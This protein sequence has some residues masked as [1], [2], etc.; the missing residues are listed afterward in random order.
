MAGEANI[1]EPRTLLEL[2]ANTKRVE[3]F[4]TA[5]EGQTVFTIPTFAYVPDTGALAIFKN[6]LA[7]AKGIDWVESGTGTSFSLVI[8]ASAGDKI[9]AV[10]YVGIT[11]E[12]AV[13]PAG[14]NILVDNFQD[15]R[16][17]AEDDVTLYSTSK[18]AIGDGGEGFF[19]LFTGASPGTYADNNKTIIVPTGGNGSAAWIKSTISRVELAAADSDVSI[20][21]VA[22]S[23]IANRAANGITLQLST[24]AGTDN[25]VDEAWALLLVDVPDG[26]CRIV[27]DANPNTVSGAWEIELPVAIP[28]NCHLDL[29]HTLIEW[30]STATG[31]T[32]K[33]VTGMFNA[34][35]AVT[36][37]ANIAA[38]I[39]SGDNVITLNTVAGISVGDYLNIEIVNNTDQT[40][41]MFPIIYDFAKV[42]AIDSLDVTLATIIDWEI[43]LLDQDTATVNIVTDANCAKNIVVTGGNFLDSG[44]YVVHSTPPITTDPEQPDYVIGPLFFQYCD[45]VY[46]DSCYGKD[47]K[48]P[49]VQ[50]REYTNCAA[51]NIYS[52]RPLAVSAGEGYTVQ[53]SRGN[54]G[55][56]YRIGG[57]YTRH[58]C[59][60][61]S[62][63]SLIMKDCW[64]DTPDTTRVSFLLHGRYESKIKMIGLKGSRL[65]M[66]A[67]FVEFG[68]FIKE[69]QLL[70]SNVEEFSGRGAIGICSIRNTRIGYTYGSL[71]FEH[72]TLDN[73]IVET[74]DTNWNRET[75]LSSPI[76]GNGLYLS[77]SSRVRAIQFKGFDRVVYDST[78]M[79]QNGG[80]TTDFVIVDGVSDLVLDGQH[81]NK[82]YKLINGCEKLTVED[83]ARFEGPNSTD[84]GGFI[85]VTDLT[86]ATFAATISGIMDSAYVGASYNR[87]FLF[88]QGTGTAYTLNLQVSKLK[89]TGTWDETA[90]IVNDVTLV[91]TCIG[92]SFEGTSSINYIDDPLT[93]TRLPFPSTFRCGHNYY[94]DDTRNY[95]NVNRTFSI[96][97]AELV[98]PGET[99]INLTIPAYVDKTSDLS[100]LHSWS[101]TLV[102]NGA[103]TGVWGD[104]TNIKARFRN[105]GGGNITFTGDL[106]L[107]TT[108]LDY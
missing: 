22:A 4:M 90:R 37:T 56:Q 57:Y 104:G 100:V 19:Q 50:F 51:S 78:S 33:R 61:T 107:T 9:I 10:G 8:S 81:I 70:E 98:T 87:P 27:V 79:H 26:Y 15:L 86:G 47:L 14:A 42:V 95:D 45:N 102:T 96:A 23:V 12:V 60:F 52:N 83:T 101:G 28:S 1:W 85:H 32:T 24:Y 6:G 66:G 91:G 65:G 16:D 2:S 40:T 25:T 68:N 3:A 63:H 48:C 55:I 44:A 5:L 89:C 41:G 13:L 88:E 103:V 76:I 74:G 21:G 36:G 106:V 62:G 75:R 43:D 73:A 30:T 35:G 38:N 67:G 59:D 34:I 20:A 17:Y 31:T 80:G 18:V 108:I 72:L 53:M 105:F 94:A 39:T 11:G 46:V 77:N 58:V 92:N 64:D 82:R 7:L 84:S 69:W 71:Y 49:L 54:R 99:T 93:G 29:G 97:L